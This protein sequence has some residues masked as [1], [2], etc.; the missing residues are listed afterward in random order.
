MKY[1]TF[2]SKGS[3][4]RESFLRKGCFKERSLLPVGAACVVANGIREMLAAMLQTGV[5]V[6]LFAPVIPDRR[7]W[8]T[9]LKGAVLLRAR[10]SVGEAAIIARPDDAGTLVRA[11]FGEIPQSADSA[12]TIERGSMS[13]IEREV[14]QRLLR[15]LSGTL[16]SICGAQAQTAVVSLRRCD[17]VRYSTY[18]EVSIE[19]PVMASL[20]IALVQDPSPEPQGALALEHLSEVQLPLRVHLSGGKISAARACELKAGD[21]LPL[22][23]EMVTALWLG[24]KELARGS[25]GASDNRYAF[26]IHEVAA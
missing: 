13:V 25:C 15:R 7:A 26:S 11:T 4:I 14:L 9:L 12:S 8:D 22:D 20:G 17:E 10:G 3:C 24:S 23:D 16:G 2:E 1:L 5:E 18:F 6:R 21:V 19:R